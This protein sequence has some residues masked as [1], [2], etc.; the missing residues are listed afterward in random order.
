MPE[1]EYISVPIT[2][3]PD[4][5]AQAA[6]ATIQERFPG[7]IPNEGNL[8]VAVIEVIS[9]IAAEIGQLASDVP[10]AIFRWF[11]A[12]V[13]NI[14]PY[15]AVAATA[16]TTW[17]MIDAQGYKIE[18]GT[19]VGLRTS[20]D[21]L[22]GFT[23]L[24]DV[25]VPP[26]VTT[27][28]TGAVQI[29]ARDEGAAASGL[30]LPGQL[31]EPIDARDFVA[32]VQLV[33]PTTNGVDPEEDDAYLTRLRNE[34]QLLTPRPILAPDFASFFVNRIPGTE[35]CLALDNY[36]P[37]PPW[38]A[39][40]AAT[41]Q[42]KTIT[43]VPVDSMGN[44]LSETA[45]AAGRSLLASMREINFRIYV[46]DPTFN[47]VAIAWGGIAL[48]GFD[49]T[50]VR[51]AGNGVLTEYLFAGNWGQP[52]SGESREWLNKPTIRFTELVTELGRVEGL[53][54]VTDIYISVNGGQAVLDGNVQMTGIAPL[55]HLTAISG[56]V[57]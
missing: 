28:A 35:R 16:Q 8:E 27:T 25:I 12:T 13:M 32:A 38:D 24:Q 7:W 34:L 51:E 22:V 52:R 1:I 50:T 43:L 44:G 17:T 54:Y 23:V 37:G 53:D 21:V 29:E 3:E 15:E 6:Y 14:P 4:D 56:D 36:K 2:V 26:G 48:P 33:A 42:E 5:F 39:D 30:G 40:P 10:A 18:A 55:P 41:D 57:Q 47:N 19:N 31:L 49:K 20:G 11:G 46:I 45:K 9:R